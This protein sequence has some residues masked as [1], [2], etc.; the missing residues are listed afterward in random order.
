MTG[1]GTKNTSPNNPSSSPN[2]SGKGSTSN[3]GQA[4]KYK[5]GVYDVKHASTKTGFEEA[6]VTIKDSKI[7]NIELKR[8]DA[9]QKEVN[10]EDWNGTKNGW[11]N[12]K[13]ARLDLAKAMINKQSSGS[14]L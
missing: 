11:P 3:T 4:I 2:N 7:Q 1:C 10:Y 5:D 13:Q 12:L 14:L 6:I 8:L 9:N